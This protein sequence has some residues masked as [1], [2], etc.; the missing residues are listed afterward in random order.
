MDAKLISA[1][2]EVW[3]QQQNFIAVIDVPFIENTEMIPSGIFWH[4]RPFVLREGLRGAHNRPVFVECKFV[5]VFASPELRQKHGPTCP[6]NCAIAYPPPPADHT[7][8]E[9]L[10]GTPVGEHQA[11]LPD[12]Q[13]K[14]YLVLTEEERAKGFIRPVRRSYRHVGALGPKY[15]LRDLTPEE[16]TRYEEYGY[17]KFEEYPKDACRGTLG[18][19]WTLEGLNSIGKGCQSI[20]TMGPELAETWAR[21]TSFYRGTFCCYCGAHLPV[22]EFVWLDDGARLGT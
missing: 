18:R 17:V 5:T 16:K 6:A 2:V 21:S 8:V 20:T 9:T 13:Q 1:E 3:D 15:A 19:F 11:L 12:G 10:H 4:T 14:D 7:K 22:E